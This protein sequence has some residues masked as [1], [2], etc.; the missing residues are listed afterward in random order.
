M[1]NVLTLIKK[2]E[3]I[4][5]KWSCSSFELQS[6]KVDNIWAQGRLE[7]DPLPKIYHHSLTFRLSAEVKCCVKKGEKWGQLIYVITGSYGRAGDTDTL[8]PGAIWREKF[9]LFYLPHLLPRQKALRMKWKVKELCIH[10]IKCFICLLL[11]LMNITFYIVG[12]VM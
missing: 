10:L 2:K 12:S 9:F 5:I 8:K 4:R 11:F 6:G 7:F 3:R 1:P